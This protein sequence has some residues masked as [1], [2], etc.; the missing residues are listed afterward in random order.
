[1][2]WLTNDTKIPAC[3]VINP[4]R[5]FNKYDSIHTSIFFVKITKKFQDDSTYVKGQ[6]ITELASNIK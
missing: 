3:I 5:N 1:M 2:M 6:K 4:L